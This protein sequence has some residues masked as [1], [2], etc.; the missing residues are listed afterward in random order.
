[1][2]GWGSLMRGCL[3]L[4]WLFRN[5]TRPSKSPRRKFSWQRKPT[6]LYVVRAFLSSAYEASLY[7][8]CTRICVRLSFV[9]AYSRHGV[10]PPRR[11]RLRIP[12]TWLGSPSSCTASCGLCA[13]LEQV[14]K[15]LKR[16]D[17]ELKKFE[18][19]LD[20][21]RPGVTAALKERTELRS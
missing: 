12:A 20:A 9:H 15:Q 19:E 11:A 2:A 21:T 5:S 3:R 4:L 8:V 17:H 7:G 18:S 16:L 14:L 13:W 10:V 1:M 6:T